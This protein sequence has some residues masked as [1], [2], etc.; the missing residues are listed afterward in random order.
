MRESA[1]VAGLNRSF[2]Y[3]VPVGDNAFDI[4]P[5][6]VM[7][8]SALAKVLRKFVA[9]NRTATRASPSP[10][11]GRQHPSPGQKIW[12]PQEMR[13]PLCSIRRSFW[14]LLGCGGEHT[15]ETGLEPS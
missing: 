7:L 13:A 12:R 2:R 8:L 4:T 5:F 10:R 1:T 14:R 11:R 6:V 15:E 9:D 3:V